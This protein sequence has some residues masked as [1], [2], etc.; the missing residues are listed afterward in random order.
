MATTSNGLPVPSS[1]RKCR[2]KIIRYRIAVFGAASPALR[3]R[4]KTGLVNLR[5]QGSIFF[6]FN[7][8]R[9]WKEWSVS[10]MR[11]SVLP[12][13]QQPRRPPQYLHI[14][15]EPCVTDIIGVP[16]VTLEDDPFLF[17]AGPM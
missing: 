6:Y 11:S 1:N 8:A 15:S 13:P 17:P 14:Q 3:H 10:R 9:S 7:A 5:K 12:S 2:W 4:W 16:P